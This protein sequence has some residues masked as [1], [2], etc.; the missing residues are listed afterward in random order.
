MGG[1]KGWGGGSRGGWW[2][3]PQDVVGELRAV[4]RVVARERMLWVAVP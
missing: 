3:F 2:L 1:R 4:D